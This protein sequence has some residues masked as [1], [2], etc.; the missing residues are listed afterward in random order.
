M[1]IRGII[2]KANEMHEPAEGWPYVEARFWDEVRSALK[3]GKS[4]DKSMVEHSEALLLDIY[5]GDRIAMAA[6]KQKREKQQ[7]NFFTL[8]PEERENDAW[9]QDRDDPG[10]WNIFISANLKSLV[11]TQGLFESSIDFFF[12]DSNTSCF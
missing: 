4:V 1:T 8:R 12:S 2:N 11:H 6:D 5:H 10:K 3:N 7:C 9:R